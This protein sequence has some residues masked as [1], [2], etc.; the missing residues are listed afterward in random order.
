MNVEV[1]FGYYTIRIR[2]DGVL[3][4]LLLRSEFLGFQAWKDN[5]TQYCIEYVMKGGSMQCEY[6][7]REKWQA[8]LAKLDCHQ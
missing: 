2:I 5:D 4:L 1:Q 8:I 6:D 3:H 7:T